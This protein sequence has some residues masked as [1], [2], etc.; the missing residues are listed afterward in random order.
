MAD[1]SVV[2]TRGG[3][4]PAV[5]ELA[6]HDALR[7]GD[8]AAFG[9]FAT[10]LQPTLRRL[11]GL[12]VTGDAAVDAVVRRS[13]SIALGGGH[14]FR[15]QTPLATWVAGIAV[16]TARG[17]PEARRGRVTT[18]ALALVTAPAPRRRGSSRPGP[19]D[20]SDLPWSGRWEGV[21]PALAGAIDGLPA[22]AREVL[23]G[24][25]LE[26]W[27]L[28]RV[29]DVFGSTERA[30]ERLLASAR[31][32]VH[33]ELAR[34]LGP[35]ESAAGG[36]TDLAAQ[37]RAL[38]RWLGQQLEDRPEPLDPG[39]VEVFHDWTTGRDRRWS[40]RVVRR[41]RAGQAVGGTSGTS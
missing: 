40:R 19:T 39:V 14:M 1:R 15:W 25:D 7:L 10:G 37:R 12:H 35:S 20:W 38:T 30:S 28:R 18:E 32:R 13:W 34:H 33:A 6:I 24:H 17:H 2:D 11:A 5:D 29:C 27:P 23:H 31:E 16:T 22:D 41:L 3:W 9:R 4:L 8:D 36:S 26:R 21:G